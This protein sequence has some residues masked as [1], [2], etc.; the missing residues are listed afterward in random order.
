M[1]WRERSE[2]RGHELADGDDLAGR[3]VWPLGPVPPASPA[4]QPY[5]S[6]HGCPA[7]ARGRRGER[8]R[9]GNDPILRC[10]TTP[11]RSGQ[12]RSLR[13]GARRTTPEAP[14]RWNADQRPPAIVSDGERVGRVWFGPLQGSHTDMYICDITI[15]ENHRG[16]V[17]AKAAIELILDDARQHHRSRVGLTVAHAYVDAVALYESLGFV[18]TGSDDSGRE[19]GASST[20]DSAPTEPAF[21]DTHRARVDP[22]TNRCRSGLVTVVVAP[23]GGT[24]R[25]PGRSRRLQR[26]VNRPGVWDRRSRPRRR[27]DGRCRT[28]T[29]GRG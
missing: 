24:R 11:G 12:R 1:I 21:R 17:H 23:G 25:L 10:R 6:G 26:E 4:A 13:A 2:R 14:P 7:A 3:F 27:R 19:I 5:G 29:A 20:R 16:Q 22:V 9:G 18:T 28:G 15:G 8:T